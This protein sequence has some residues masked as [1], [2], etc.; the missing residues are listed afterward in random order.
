MLIPKW[1]IPVVPFSQRLREHHGKWGRNESWRMGGELCHDA[2]MVLMIS[3]HPH[4]CFPSAEVRGGCRLSVASE[5]LNSG[6]DAHAASALLTEP[7]LQ[8]HLAS[9]KFHASI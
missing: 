1:D 8:P 3:Q 6:L 4:L 5:E 2:V 7:P 9:D